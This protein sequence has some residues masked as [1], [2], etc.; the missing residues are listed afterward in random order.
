MKVKSYNQHHNP[1]NFLMGRPALHIGEYSSNYEKWL[2]A[3]LKE[4]NT[5]H[6][7]GLGLDRWELKHVVYIS[8]REA[9]L[10]YFKDL[11]S[12]N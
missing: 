4:G 3:E 11:L 10:H 12:T 6:R 2:E 8:D 5:A 7:E 1:D 9:L